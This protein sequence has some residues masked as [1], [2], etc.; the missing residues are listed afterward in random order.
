MKWIAFLFMLLCLWL[1]LG[2]A[3]F[4]P[5]PVDRERTAITVAAAIGALV[6]AAWSGTL[7]KKAG[8]TK[9]IWISPPV[10]VV[11]LVLLASAGYLAL[12][13]ISYR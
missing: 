9:S 7:F 11:A 12:Q 1:F 3:F 10:I 8:D 5:G 13:S 4:A 6:F 2:G